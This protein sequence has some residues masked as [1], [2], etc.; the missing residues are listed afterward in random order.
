MKTQPR[1]HIS[2]K[3]NTYAIVTSPV[4]IGSKYRG[5]SNPWNKSVGLLDIASNIS[6]H[7]ALKSILA[8]CQHG[9]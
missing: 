6:K 2:N 8:D 4:Y 3:Y 1:Q 9:F 7:L 5:R